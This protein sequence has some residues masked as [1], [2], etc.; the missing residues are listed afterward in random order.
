M[1]ESAFS[2]PSPVSSMAHH[3]VHRK[4]TVHVSGASEALAPRAQTQYTRAPTQK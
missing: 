1:R 4:C 2:V 3:L